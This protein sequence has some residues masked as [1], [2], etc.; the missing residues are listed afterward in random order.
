M[1]SGYQVTEVS[2]RAPAFADA[3]G[4]K[5]VS[6]IH[7]H[8][9]GDKPVGHAPLTRPNQAYPPGIGV[10]P[11]QEATGI[12]RNLVLAPPPGLLCGDDGP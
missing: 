8:G 7:I 12:S 10:T 1:F 2:G 6:R 9:M 11:R 5:R 4:E 3:H